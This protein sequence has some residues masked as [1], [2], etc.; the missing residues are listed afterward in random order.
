MF[1]LV[2]K[3]AKKNNFPLPD[4]EIHIWA[5]DLSKSIKWLLRVAFNHLD[6]CICQL[7]IFTTSLLI[8]PLDCVPLAGLNVNTQLPSS[9]FLCN[10][11]N[12]FLIFDILLYV[13]ILLASSD[14]TFHW[15]SNLL[16]YYIY[17]VILFLLWT[18]THW[19]IYEL[20][21]LW[22]VIF[23]KVVLIQWHRFV[24]P[25]VFHG[26]LRGVFLQCPLIGPHRSSTL[27]LFYKPTLIL[28]LP[29]TTAVFRRHGV[30]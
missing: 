14:S 12:L 8:W 20:F 16:L 3:Q 2:L 30:T 21:L 24:C 5:C 25:G 9:L 26:I 27:L 6:P 19:L 13:P 22:W 29:I 4:A 10:C 23:F 28:K 1:H 7:C 15:S 11:I 18:Y 17:T